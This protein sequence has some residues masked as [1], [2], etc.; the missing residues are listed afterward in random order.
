MQVF[1]ELLPHFSTVGLPQQ[2]RGL[3]LIH[4]CQLPHILHLCPGCH[5]FLPQISQLI[6]EYLKL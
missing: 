4:F 1:G 3:L 6:V 2:K 5:H